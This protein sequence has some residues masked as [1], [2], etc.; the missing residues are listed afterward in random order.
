M[1]KRSTEIKEAEKRRLLY[2]CCEEHLGDAILKGNANVI[3]LREQELLRMIKQ[4]AII[5]VLV[6]VRQ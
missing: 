6:V 3:N 2:Q 1:F 4:L 5:L